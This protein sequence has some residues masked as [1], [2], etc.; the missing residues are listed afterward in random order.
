MRLI[1]VFLISSIFSITASERVYKLKDFEKTPKTLGQVTQLTVR[2]SRDSLVSK[3]HNLLMNGRPSRF[4]GTAGHKN[5]QEF[6][7]N[8]I[9]RISPSNPATVEEFALD[10]QAI[11]AS[12]RADFDN[13]LKSGV[14]PAATEAVQMRLFTESMVSVLATQKDVVGKNIIWS[15]KGFLQPEEVLIIGAHYDTIAQDPEKLIVSATEKMP[16]ADNNGS[17]VAAALALIEVL[18]QVNLPKSV[19][20][21]FFDGEELGQSGSKAFVTK[22]GEELKKQK[23]AGFVNLLM[24]GHDT[25]H[26]DKTNKTGNMRFYTRQAS[27]D[28]KGSVQDMALA[29]LLNDA[30]S[31]VRSSVSFEPLEKKEIASS[32]IAF[33]ALGIPSIVM[34]HDWEND[35]NSAHHTKQDF[36]ETLNFTTFHNSTQFLMGAVLA[37][38]FDMR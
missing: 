10:A 38:A 24:L 3:L 32:H 14:E 7:I 6:I 18:E 8:E 19:M 25:L 16:G 30:G 23:L 35:F 1:F 26:Q 4:I 2:Y 17:G 31:K 5:A 28:E 15:K 13:Y 27:V 9:K 22:N 33:Q 34:T 29:K 21:V 11:S 36:A 37:W 12:Y 20:V